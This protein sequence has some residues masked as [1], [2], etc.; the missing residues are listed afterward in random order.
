[1]ADEVLA[2][3]FLRKKKRKI[4]TTFSTKKKIK[5]CHESSADIS[6]FLKD[7]IWQSFLDNLKLKLTKDKMLNAYKVIDSKKKIPPII[8]ITKLPKMKKKNI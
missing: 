3:I 4:S 6:G 2:D 1:M 7:L 5:K 8:P